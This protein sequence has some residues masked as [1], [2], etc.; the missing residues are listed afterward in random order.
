M[1]VLFSLMGY[2]QKEYKVGVNLFR[3]VNAD[4]LNQYE[5]TEM[6]LDSIVASLAANNPQRE[7]DTGTSLKKIQLVVQLE[8]PW[9]LTE[10]SA[11]DYNFT[12]YKNF[13]T[14]CEDRKIKWTALLSPHN[15]PG[16][17]RDKYSADII[18]KV[19]GSEVSSPFLVFS[20]SSKVW[21]DPDNPN[22]GEV[23][24]WI[25]E[26]V[27][28]M[29]E[30]NHFS[31]LSTNSSKAID[32]ILIGNEMIYPFN[33]ETSGDDATKAKWEAK[34]NSLNSYPSTIQ[35]FVN[36][37]QG[38]YNT[39]YDTNGNFVSSTP[40]LVTNNNQ[41]T[42]MPNSL[43]DFRNSEL[44][45]C[46]AGMFDKAKQQLMISFGND[47]ADVNNIGISS[48]LV[49]YL[50]RR[51]YNPT[52][53]QPS[54]VLSDEF[55]GYD[56]PN[57]GYIID[58]SNKFLG[59]DSYYTST[60][61]LTDSFIAT[62]SRTNPNNLTTP[63]KSI[64]LA[65]F[66]KNIGLTGKVPL[67]TATE[68]FSNGRKGFGLDPNYQDYNVRYYVFFA[69]NPTYDPT[70]PYYKITEG[71]QLGLYNLFNSIATRVPQSFNN[72]ATTLNFEEEPIDYYNFSTVVLTD[73][74]VSPFKINKNN[75][76]SGAYTVAN[77]ATY[78][79]ITSLT[80]SKNDV[81]WFKFNWNGKNY[82]LK[83]VQ[84]S[85]IIE[86]DYLKQYGLNFQFICN[87]VF[88]AYTTKASGVNGVE[89]DTKI[90][91]YNADLVEL[92]SND[93]YNGVKTFSKIYYNLDDSP[94]PNTF[95]QNSLREVNLNSSDILSSSMKQESNNL[96]MDNNQFDVLVSP[97][98]AVNYLDVSVTGYSEK[99]N[100]L[101]TDLNGKTVYQEQNVSESK[102]T[103]DV[104]SINE[105][106]YCL[107]VT[108][109]NDKKVKKIIK[110]AK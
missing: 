2:S 99:Y 35:S 110:L 41:T 68:I 75:F 8:V 109:D 14:W 28:Q 101:L 102:K 71:Q 9:D 13:A 93:D 100:V 53:G 72:A 70:E 84:Q 66:N 77:P 107:I 58:H 6:T 104:S 87:N 59:A 55:C 36:G 15:V 98:P 106:M 39:T 21:N 19:D 18:R 96:S 64:Y 1:V 37:W 65:E 57:L 82:Y 47:T 85:N 73:P 12:W 56:D 42:W 97:N 81:D 29:S 60:Y 63:S 24:K 94:L 23:G 90:F 43:R 54:T 51:D 78:S 79:N 74:P 30:T 89:V 62:K 76:A 7:S 91:L 25:K 31:R 61:S 32:E 10:P 88:T 48:K 49:P 44:A 20:P 40:N 45:Y 83:V 103:I 5:I 34:G 3:Y 17:I 95:V 27:K 86:P 92:A 52:T 46:I 26:F 108:S 105:G 16:F 69:W 22:N 4:K 38:F 11:G 67:M 50:F 33:K 80:I